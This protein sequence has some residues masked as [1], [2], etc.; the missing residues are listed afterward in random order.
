[1][2]D[3]IEKY[4]VEKIGANTQVIEIDGIKY[5]QSYESIVAKY[6]TISEELV[7]LPK[8]DYSETTLK[9]VS[10]FVREQTKFHYENKAE[11]EKE[12]EKNVCIRRED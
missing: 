7:L 12:I 8:W 2:R 10:R 3:F 6:N 1:M 4:K 9:H 11:F 5:L